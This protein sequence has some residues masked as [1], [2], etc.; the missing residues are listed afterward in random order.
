MKN[1]FILLTLALLSFAQLQAQTY[2]TGVITLSATSGLAMTA[3]I[4][5]GAQVTLTLTGPAGRWFA[6][7]FDASSMSSG[8]DV[9]SVHS[10][11]AL[12]AFDCE[13]TGYAAPVADGQ[14]NW[15]ITS[16]AVSGSVRTIVATRA[17]NTGDPSDYV[18]AAAPTVIGL[19]WARSGSATFSYSYHG[20]ANRG[21]VSNGF[22]F[23]P[24]PTPPAAP[25]GA[26]NQ[27]FCTGATLAQINMSGTA[28]QWY[29]SP[30]STSALPNNTVLVN[31]AT[32]YASQTV[33]GLQSI[34]RTAVTISLLAAPV[35]PSSINGLVNFCFGSG[36]QQYNIVGIAGATSYV[37]T[38]PVGTTGS[39]TGTNIGLLFTPNFQSGTLSVLAQNSCGQSS[40]TSVVINQYQAANSTLNIATCNSYTFN[41]ITY[42]QSGTYS[43]SGTTIWGCDSIVVLYLDISP[44][45]ATT[46]EAEACGSYPWNGQTFYTSGTYFDSLQTSSGCDSIVTLNLNIYPIVANT[47]DSTVL[48]AFIWNGINYNTSGTYTQFFTSVNG[49]DSTVTINLTIEDSGLG[50]Q[51]LQILQIA[52]NPVGVGQVLDIIGIKTNMPFQIID[53]QG[54][55]VQS[56]QTQGQITL[57]KTLSDGT[58]WLKINRQS[59]AVSIVK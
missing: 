45:I 21:A 11:A 42:N 57:S 46:I 47:I 31:G 25:V 34:N 48:D 27:T 38:T 41:G 50:A 1:S 56:G 9:V 39:S 53:Q 15:T 32:Y 35:A 51:T 23:I 2:T 58:Y 54:K 6:I 29:A 33:N 16:D 22:T 59:L 37:W 4:D 43:S 12:N 7:G 18:F 13:L 8:T 17:L 26:A 3:K 19:I 28:I 24:A 40:S 5:V 52:P 55:V 44:T 36:N 49:C 30:T 20:S 10:A 14:Q